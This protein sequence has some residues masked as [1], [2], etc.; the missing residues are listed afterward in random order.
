MFRIR[1]A[2]TNHDSEEVRAY[3]ESTK[4]LQDMLSSV[5]KY[6]RVEYLHNVNA[7]NASTHPWEDVRD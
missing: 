4:G 6:P 5:V 1:M 2:L 7:C 3:L